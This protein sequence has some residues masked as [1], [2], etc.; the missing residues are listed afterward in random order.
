M[1][2]V[3]YNFTV[4]AGPFFFSGYLYCLFYFLVVWLLFN[5]S[6]DRFGDI[7]FFSD[8]VEKKN[9]FPSGD[10]RNIAWPRFLLAIRSGDT[11]TLS[12]TI[13]S[14]NIIRV[15]R[16]EI[17]LNPVLNFHTPI[18]K[19]AIYRIHIKPI[20][21]YGAT[22]RGP[23]LSRTNRTKIEAVQNVA[24]RTI[25]GVENSVSNEILHESADMRVLQEEARH[26]AGISFNRNQVLKYYSH[27]QKL[28]RLNTTC[29]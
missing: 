8:T 1:L 17:V 28:G 10:D 11:R 29:T 20:L 5:F 4:A 23:L 21:L 12:T 9:C 16:H 18:P 7:F 6:V 19:L 2:S 27:L 22:A 13:T 3:G 24:L 15:N 26:L 14:E 25:T